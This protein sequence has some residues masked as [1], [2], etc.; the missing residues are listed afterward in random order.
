MEVPA[1]PS[2][3]TQPQLP[4]QQQPVQNP[5]PSPQTTTQAQQPPQEP[6]G[7]SQK[8]IFLAIVLIVI[9]AVI[10]S[11]VYFLMKPTP[12]PSSQIEKTPT[13]PT[14]TP[15][16][17]PDNIESRTLLPTGTSDTQLESD[18]QGV[19]LDLGK[20]EADLGSVDQGLNDQSVNLS[21]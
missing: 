6:S 16:V 5:V 20:V 13:V 2:T 10:M 11:M 9:I 21:E 1:Q 12:S 3:D 18:S 15:S 4:S 7:G 17:V 19:D 8:L 14:A